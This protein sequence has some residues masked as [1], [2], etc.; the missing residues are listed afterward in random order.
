MTSWFVSSAHGVQFVPESPWLGK[1]ENLD[2]IAW[3]DVLGYRRGWDVRYRGKAGTDNWFHSAIPTLELHRHGSGRLG[4]IQVAF[5]A[6]GT[7]TVEGFMCR[8]E[9]IEYS[10][11]MDSHSRVSSLS[12]IPF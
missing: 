7:A 12:V 2:G 10:L 8:A 5:E 11:R 4:E 6:S 9:V 1:F 3:T